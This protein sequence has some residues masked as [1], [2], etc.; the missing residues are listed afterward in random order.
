M[1]SSSALIL[2]CAIALTLLL[3]LVGLAAIVLGLLAS[4]LGGTSWLIFTALG[5]IAL[6][7]GFIFALKIVLPAWR[8]AREEDVQ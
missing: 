5:L 1:R 4:I 7:S 2:A 3:I 8:M 6:G